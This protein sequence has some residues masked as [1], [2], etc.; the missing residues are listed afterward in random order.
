MK[1]ARERCPNELEPNPAAVYLH[2]ASGRR[3]C[4]ACA[5]RVNDAAGTELVARRDVERPATFDH[6]G[7]AALGSEGS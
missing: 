7:G 6:G 1:C 3:Y 4:P 5:R 2:Q